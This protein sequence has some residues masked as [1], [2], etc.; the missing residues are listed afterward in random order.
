MIES[1][2]CNR[3]LLTETTIKNI[4][5]KLAAKKSLRKGEHFWFGISGSWRKTN[6]EVEQA[7]RE[8]VRKILSFNGGI[9]TGGA[10]NV[11]FFA[12]DEALRNDPAAEKIRVYLPVTLGRY[13]SHYRKRADEGVITHEQAK[14][15]IRQLT[16]LK[17]ANPEALIENP[18]NIKVNKDTYFERNTA[19]MNASDALVAFQVNESEGVEDTV[20]KALDQG[21]PVLRTK[22][23]I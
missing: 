19:V 4:F 17:N 9:V 21:K 12:T 20:A 14:A 7:V 23:V 10:L 13:A 6:K 5:Q 8:S 16:K 3:D 22:Y 11:D 18:D 1:F 2:E 15:L